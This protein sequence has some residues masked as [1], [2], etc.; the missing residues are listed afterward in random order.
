MQP[1][2]VAS[3]RQRRQRNPGTIRRSIALLGQRLRARFDV[4]RKLLIANG[5][6]H[7]PPLPRPLTLD[8]VRVGAEHVGEIAADLALVDKTGQAAG[9][10]KDAQQRNLGEAHRRRAI[11]DE[12]D[13][14]ARERQ[15]VSPAGGRAVQGGHE[16]QPRMAA[17]VLDAV[18]RLVG[19]L[20]EVHFPLVARLAE[21]VDVG[22]GAEHAI[23]GA[24]DDDGAD[25][26]MLEADP[27]QQI[28][29]LDVDAEIVGV[30]LELVAGTKTAVFVDVHRD[31]GDASLVGDA[32][33]LI[34]GGIG[35]IVDEAGAGAGVELGGYGGFSLLH[36]TLLAPGFPKPE[37]EP[38]L[39]SRTTKHTKLTKEVLGF[40]L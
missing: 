14:V 13:L 29:Q 18:P 6:V 3:A 39:L 9:A 35:L 11:V 12:H 40:A 33:V 4:L 22:A 5:G 32:P 27:L 31:G 28:V 20:A 1:R 30:E 15:L 8:A 37:N 38:R 19:E 21:H 23:A 26:G 7:E 10:G 24:G 17:G 25:L 36:G 34:A 2:V 16:F